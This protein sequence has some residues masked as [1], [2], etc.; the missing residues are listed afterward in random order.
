MKA[1]ELLR[2]ERAT[3][4]KVYMSDGKILIDRGYGLRLEGRIRPGLDIPTV[5]E[6]HRQAFYGSPR[7]G[8]VWRRDLREKMVEAFPSLEDRV[9]AFTVIDLLGSDADGAWAALGDHGIDTDCETI[10]EIYELIK[11]ARNEKQNSVSRR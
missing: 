10:S 2:V 5:V 9:F 3:S 8:Y 11:Q 7:A 4:R 6:K 1:T